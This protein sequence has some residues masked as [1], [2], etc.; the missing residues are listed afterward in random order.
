[1]HGTGNRLG[2]IMVVLGGFA[3]GS[4]TGCG[5]KIEPH[6]EFAG[7]D[8]RPAEPVVASSAPL[9]TEQR[10][11][12]EEAIQRLM[13]MTNSQNP[14]VRANAI[15]GLERLG[16]RAEPAVA[17]ALQD[18]NPGVRSVAAIV[19]GRAGLPDLGPTLRTMLDDESEFVRAS[20]A[21]SLFMLRQ[22]VDPSELSAMLLEGRNPRIRA[23]AAFLIGEMGDQSAI[24]MLR[25]AW[26]TPIRS[27]SEIERRLVRL[28]IAEALIKLGDEASIDAVRAAL[29]PAR[30]EELEATALAVQIIGEVRDRGS[31]DQLIHLSDGEGSRVMPAEVRLAVAGALAKMGLTQGGF[32][33][34]EYASNPSEAVRAQA[35]MV[36]GRTGRAEHLPR[37]R[38]ML[39]DPSELVRVAAAAG[40]VDLALGGAQA[41]AAGS[42]S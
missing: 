7:S 12:R 30:P 31:I 26:A 36:Y 29:Y 25:Q 10:P 41:D 16:S 20:A 8:A 19:V 23:H 3:A 40:V 37:L 32:I 4:L 22:R 1:M 39:D 21:A 24:P 13:A 11:L 27:A 2:S 34:A 14:Q 42:G 18:E 5:F 28:Q 9:P 38:A 35:A 15:E 6:P 33:A 17:L